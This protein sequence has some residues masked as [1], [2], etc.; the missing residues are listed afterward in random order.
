[1][2]KI[3]GEKNYLAEFLKIA[4]LSHALWRA[5][6]ALS[7]DQIELK[8]PALDLG[9]GFGEF[10]GVVFGKVETGIDINKKELADALKNKKYNKVVWADA[11]ALPFAAKSYSTVIAVS[12]LEHI[13]NAEIVIKEVGR[14]LKKGGTFAFSVPTTEINKHLLVPKILT[15]LGLE[16][17]A[18]KYLE[19]HSLAFKHVTLKPATWWE[20]TLKKCGFKIEKAEGTI[21][22]TVLK[23]HEFFLISAFPSQFFKLFFGKRLVVSIGLRSGILPIFFSRFIRLNKDS[24]INMFFIAR[25]NK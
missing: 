21:S 18:K 6:E 2:K 17:S 13:E 22:P 15:F 5:V 10:S 9:C 4:P 7:F 14:I 24:K 8:N 23:L 11:R 3:K 20:E 16:K 19:L 12:V 25:K 1:M